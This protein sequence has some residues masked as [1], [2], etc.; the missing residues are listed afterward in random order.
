[1]ILVVDNYD[2]FTFNLVQY[3]LELGAEVVVRRNDAIGVE[4]ASAMAP[5]G[6]LLSPGPG[7]PSQAGI[8]VDLVQR[9]GEKVP[10]LGVCLGHQSIAAAHGGEIVRAEEVMHGKTSLVHHDGTGVF[11]A[12]PT[13]FEATRYHSLLVRRESLPDG[14]RVTAWTE[15]GEIMGLAHRDRPI[16]GVQFHPESILSAHGHALLAN[17][18]KRCGLTPKDPAAPSPVP[19]A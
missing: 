10:L 2:S 17:W 4:E 16:E 13:P 6:I 8:T 7:D 15:A 12:L 5:A 11:A 18:L 9:L 14:L 19:V 1:V 3:L